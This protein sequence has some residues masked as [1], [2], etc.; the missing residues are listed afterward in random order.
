CQKVLGRPENAI[1]AMVFCTCGQG[2]TVP[3]E[4]MAPEPM[5]QAAVPLPETARVEPLS[6]ESSAP[7]PLMPEPSAPPRVGRRG[8]RYQHDPNF[9]FNHDTRPKQ[10]ICDDCGLPFCD[11]CIVTFRGQTLCGPCK[12]YAA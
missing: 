3:W 2:L 4:S 6:F 10:K 8:T 12:N 1:G 9:C 5:H 11:D 7:P